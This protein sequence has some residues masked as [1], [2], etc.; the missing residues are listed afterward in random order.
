MI[1]DTKNVNVWH[2]MG[3]WKQGRFKKIQKSDELIHY[4]IVQINQYKNKNIAHYMYILYYM[5]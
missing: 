1:L 5:I 3:G 4:L 2:L